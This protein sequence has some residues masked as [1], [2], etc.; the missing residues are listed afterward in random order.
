MK[1]SEQVSGLKDG[2]EYN[3]TEEDDAINGEKVN[4]EEEEVDDKKEGD[5]EDNKTTITTG[6][7]RKGGGV[8]NEAKAPS[9][10]EDPMKQNADENRKSEEEE[11]T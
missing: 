8:G 1:Y 9:G 5:I 2:W 10:K 4:T 11:A 3:G 7:G 6:K